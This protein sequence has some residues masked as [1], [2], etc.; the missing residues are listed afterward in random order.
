MLHGDFFNAGFPWNPL[1]LYSEGKWLSDLKIIKEKNVPSIYI[2][3]LNLKRY[4]YFPKYK[5]LFSDFWKHLHISKLFI[6]NHEQFL[7]LQQ[8]I[9]LF[10]K[11]MIWFL[12]NIFLPFFQS[13]LQKFIYGVTPFDRTLDLQL[14]KWMLWPLDIGILGKG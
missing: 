9:Q 10:E 6:I 5:G 8:Y 3:C 1:T 4:I 7:H 2:I 14:Q 12:V 11:I 13:R